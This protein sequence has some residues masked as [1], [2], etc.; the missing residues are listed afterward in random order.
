M[1]YFTFQLARQNKCDLIPVE[2]VSEA[3]IGKFDIKCKCQQTGKLL[4]FVFLTRKALQ[5]RPWA[6]AWTLIY[7]VCSTILRVMQGMFA[8]ASNTHERTHVC[9]ACTHTFMHAASEPLTGVG[10]TGLGCQ[11]V[12]AVRSSRRTR[13]RSRSRSRNIYFSTSVGRYVAV[14]AARTVKILIRTVDCETFQVL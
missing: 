9:C 7:H 6:N 14:A 3:R 13:S 4:L 12:N 10:A 5:V 1:K 11:R 2:T 8:C